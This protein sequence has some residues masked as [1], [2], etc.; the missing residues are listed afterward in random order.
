MALS[1]YRM[2]IA[3]WSQLDTEGSRMT[4]MEPALHPLHLPPGPSD[5]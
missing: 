1:R 2:W 5:L 3:G 4:P